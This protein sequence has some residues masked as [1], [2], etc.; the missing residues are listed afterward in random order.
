M[1]HASV[2]PYTLV[3]KQPAKTS[4]NTLMEKKVHLLRLEKRSQPD[5]YGLGECGPLAGLS[6]DDVPDFENHLQQVVAHLNDGA[7]PPELDLEKRPSIRF[8]LESALLDLEN[9]GRRLLFPSA[10]TTGKQSIPINGLLWMADKKDLLQQLEQKIAAGFTCIKMKVGALDFDEECQVLETIRKKYSAFRIELRVDANGAFP[11]GDAQAMIKELQRF[12][13]HS[14]EQPIKAGQWEAMQE[15]CA[16]TKL[17]IALDEELIGLDPHTEGARM[18]AFIQP[19]YLIIKPGLI[20]GFDSSAKWIQLAE[21][22]ARGWW[23]TSALESNIG[24]NAI[25][26]FA[27]TYPLNMPQGLGTGQLYTNNFPA[28]LEIKDGALH[29]NHLLPWQ[30]SLVS[31]A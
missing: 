24:L 28:P 14:I 15:L 5:I 13:L 11:A 6:V 26:Q 3:F 31:L 25:A 23:I 16:K 9:G 27:A 18:V 12:E 20:G 8:G 2:V 30:L 1:F 21:K 17:P 7:L 22:H 29:Y 10:F 4:R 19:Q